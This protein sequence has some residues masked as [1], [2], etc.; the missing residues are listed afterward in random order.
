MIKISI[1]VIAFFSGLTWMMILFLG[2]PGV[3][4]QDEIMHFL[5]SKYS[6][7]DPTLLF[8]LWGR[9]GSTL[10]YMPLSPF[11]LMA[12]RL[13]SVLFACGTVLCATA[14]AKRAGMKYFFL[15]PFLLWF[16]PWFNNLSSCVLTEVPF[17]FF[18]ILS[19]YF[20][21]TRKNLLASCC[22]GFLPLIRYEAIVLLLIWCIY[23]LINRQWVPT[24]VSLV[25]IVLY[26]LVFYFACSNTLFSVYLH[27][28]GS[29]W[30]SPDPQRVFY[31]TGGWTHYLRPLFNRIGG[32]VFILSILSIGRLNKMTGPLIVV[33]ILYLAYFL[34]HVI[35]YHFGLYASDGDVLFLLPLAPAFAIAAAAGLEIIE[36]NV[37]QLRLFIVVISIVL[38]IIVGIRFSHFRPLGSEAHHLKQAAEFLHHKNI[39]ADK[40]TA[41][42]VWFYYYFDLPVSSKTIWTNFV[43]LDHFSSGHILVWDQRYSDRWGASYHQL[44]D[45]ANEWQ[46][47]TRINNFVVIFQKK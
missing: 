7:H 23:L 22:F 17:S 20:L 39:P 5:I 32:P 8:D 4:T 27:P 31:P 29:W 42:H 41:T 18:L 44:T 34:L 38:V 10:C 25:P 3:I 30:F 21:L 45:P 37:Q 47:L 33:S 6:W 11:G 43:D 16:Q 19:F 13:T 26:N 1:L 15:V 9:A 40:I 46:E 2:S 36:N 28:H 24:L 12:A 35:G 14:L